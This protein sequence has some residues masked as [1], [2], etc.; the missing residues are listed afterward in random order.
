[1]VEK[2]RADTLY[3]KRRIDKPKKE[4][5]NFARKIYQ[6][7]S[8]GIASCLSNILQEIKGQKVNCDLVVCMVL[9]KRQS[10]DEKFDSHGHSK[11]KYFVSNDSITDWESSLKQYRSNPVEAVTNPYCNLF[12]SM[13]DER[14]LSL[15]EQ[16]NI[17]SSI[18]NHHKWMWPGKKVH[19]LRFEQRFSNSSRWFP[20]SPRSRIIQAIYNDDETSVVIPCLQNILGEKVCFNYKPKRKSQKPKPKKCRAGGNLCEA[21]GISREEARAIHEGVFMKEFWKKWVHLSSTVNVN[22]NRMD[23]SRDS[24]QD[25]QVDNVNES[26]ASVDV[27]NNNN[28]RELENQV[29]VSTENF[30]DTVVAESGNGLENEV[31]LTSQLR[32][33]LYAYFCGELFRRGTIAW[34]VST[35]L[36]SVML[37]NAY[38]CESGDF[39]PYVFVHVSVNLIDEQYV[40]SCTCLTFSTNLSPYDGLISTCCHCRLLKESMSNKISSLFINMSKVEDA[41]RLHQ[42]EVLQLASKSG[43][44]RFSVTVNGIDAEL[45]T[46]FYSTGTGKTVVKCHSSKCQREQGSCRDV[47]RLFNNATLCPHLS[48]FQSFY[49]QQVR[50]SCEGLDDDNEDEDDMTDGLDEE[51]CTLMAAEWE[52]SI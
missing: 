47:K 14:I 40:Y 31:N 27:V 15:E 50:L 42:V 39:L 21:L 33:S 51:D 37:M 52:K 22:V 13:E 1:M 7:S 41:K 29:G 6:R 16:L 34:R 35:E 43:V 17:L 10:W 46:L 49:S 48:V 44:D 3:A 36:E 2:Q 24:D 5:K 26:T 25:N 4:Y 11:Q 32:Q 28:D 19:S 9:Q 12:D 18:P 45:V 8:T 23:A 38:H 20:G 30:N